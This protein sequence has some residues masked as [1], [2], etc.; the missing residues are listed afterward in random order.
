MAP[1]MNECGRPSSGCVADIKCKTKTNYKRYLRSA[2]YRGMDFPVSREDWRKV[3]NSDK[4]NDETMT[5]NCLPTSAWYKHYSS[6]FSVINYSVHS[7]YTRLPTPLFS[8]TFS[9]RHI[10]PISFSSVINAVKSLKSDS[11]DKDGISKMHMPI[12]CTPLISH[13]QLLFQMCLCTSYVPESFLY[14]TVSSILKRGKSLIDCSC[15]RLITVFGNISKVFE[16]ILLPFLTKNIIEDENQF[17]FRSGVGCQ[18]AHRILSSLLADNSSKGNGL[19][20]CALDLSKAFDSV[21]HSQLIFSLYNSL[22][23]LSIIMLLRF[24]YS[25]SF[26][27]LGSA[28]DTIIRTRRGVRQGGVLS[29]M[30]FKICISSVL[31]KISGTYLSGLA[32][33]S[34]LAY[35]DDL[36]LISR[37]KKGFSKMVS[38]VS[39][40]FS[41]I[42][43]SINIDKC[44]FLP[45]NVLLLLPF[46]VITSLSLLS[47]V[48]VGL[49]SLLLTIFRAYVSVLFVI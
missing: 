49:V 40:A 1:D 37:P 8:T 21:V 16:Y 6:I 11:I 33:V 47:I 36:L 29:P 31:A 35:A 2:R 48:F 4:I 14:G 30:L 23:N 34:Y 5:S 15:Y 3:I 20:I 13:F 10:V 12:E 41:D 17:G 39:D 46:T 27:Q 25:N 28:P 42:G 32:N 22:V 9:Q 43:L 18:H 45:Y 26:L 44:E 24:W 7:V 19:Y 38:I